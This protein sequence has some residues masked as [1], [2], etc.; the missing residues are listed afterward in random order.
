MG[1]RR[2]AS[3][4]CRSPDP[5]HRQGGHRNS[6]NHP[7]TLLR[8][9]ESH[10]SMDFCTGRTFAL[11][12]SYNYTFFLQ[13][14]TGHLCSPPITPP[15]ILRRIPFTHQTT[16]AFDHLQ[17]PQVVIIEIKSEYQSTLPLKVVTLEAKSTNPFFRVG[18]ILSLHLHRK[19]FRG[20]S[21]EDSL[22]GLLCRAGR[23]KGSERRLKLFLIKRSK[24]KVSFVP[25]QTGRKKWGAGRQ[26]WE[27]RGEVRTILSPLF[28]PRCAR[29]KRPVGAARWSPAGQRLFADQT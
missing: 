23:L 24:D 2:S 4:R 13:M 8:S 9:V 17:S 7:S 12:I 15:L 3:L 1:E 14:Q 27:T 19:E 26:T 21:Q 22:R 29:P 11:P 10:D 25:K 20:P 16:R 18:I 6:C 28:F 5:A